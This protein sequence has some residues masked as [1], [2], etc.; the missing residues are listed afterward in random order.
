MVT[1]EKYGV[2]IFVN[3]NCTYGDGKKKN[4]MGTKIETVHMGQKKM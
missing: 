4:V 1:R 3:R 2:Y